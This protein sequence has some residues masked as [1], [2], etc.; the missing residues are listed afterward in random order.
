MRAHGT[1]NKPFTSGSQ[2][3]G[4]GQ[5]RARKGRKP[6][7]LRQELTSI[8]TGRRNPQT[9]HDADAGD[10][11]GQ[12]KPKR[13]QGGSPSGVQVLIAMWQSRKRAAKGRA[14]GGRDP[15][16][17]AGA[18]LNSSFWAAMDSRRQQPKNWQLSLGT[19]LRA[20]EVYRRR[21]ARSLSDK[22]PPPTSSS[23]GRPRRKTQAD[24]GMNTERR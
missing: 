9:G 21:R 22:V 12:D 4:A 7:L 5:V 1:G 16:E 19:Q 10:S 6:H 3:G 23:S 15:G 24:A 20:T 8:R 11:S 14:S 2:D 18:Q 13:C 17:D